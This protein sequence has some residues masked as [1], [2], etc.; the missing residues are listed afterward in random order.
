M[1]GI[2]VLVRREPSMS[3]M[4]LKNKKKGKNSLNRLRG[5]KITI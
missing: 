1:S 3:R 4:R 5:Q 2:K